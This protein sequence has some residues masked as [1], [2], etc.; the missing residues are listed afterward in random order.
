MP[1]AG[2]VG[3]QG[4]VVAVDLAERLVR[5]GEAKARAQGLGN[6]EFR[7]EDML[8]LSYRDAAI[9]VVVCVFGIVFLASAQ[10]APAQPEETLVRITYVA[11]WV[12]TLHEKRG[13]GFDRPCGR[14]EAEP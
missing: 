7:V 13:G 14:R 6:I 3:P 11:V 12:S 1:A 4:K 9:D 8:A 10:E 2:A 5:L